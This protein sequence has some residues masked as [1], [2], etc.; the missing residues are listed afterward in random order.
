MG[1]AL[2]DGA[3]LVE[4]GADVVVVGA[5]VV[6]GAALEVVEIRPNSCSRLAASVKN[7]SREAEAT[8]L[9]DAALVT[10]GVS[11]PT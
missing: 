6:E 1:V 4:E 9:V 8:E 2:V 10:P 3:A 5:E 11:R 7:L